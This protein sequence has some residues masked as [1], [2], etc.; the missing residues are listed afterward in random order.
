M[1]SVDNVLILFRKD[2]NLTLRSFD[3]KYVPFTDIFSDTGISHEENA[4]DYVYKGTPE[5]K[6]FMRY[7]NGELS[8]DDLKDHWLIINSFDKVVWGEKKSAL[9]S[10]ENNL[11]SKR[12]KLYKDYKLNQP[13]YSIADIR[14]NKF[15]FGIATDPKVLI[16]R[17]NRYK[18]PEFIQ[19]LCVL[20]ISKYSLLFNKR[21]L[22]D[23]CGTWPAQVSNATKILFNHDTSI[24]RNDPLKKFVSEKE[25]QKYNNTV[26][27]ARKAIEV[28]K[29]EGNLVSVHNCQHIWLKRYHKVNG[30][31]N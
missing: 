13:I 1:P 8:F 14:D 24:I 20:E 27:N 29:C 19:Y 21:T 18:D 9:V 22:E 3:Q 6:N 2:D 12:H 16:K 11:G 7:M 15:Y 10:L 5:Y 23:V 25:S 26:K 17:I 28:I 30:L 4:I 31:N